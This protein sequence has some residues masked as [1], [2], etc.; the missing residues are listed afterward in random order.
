MLELFLPSR[1]IAVTNG[2]LGLGKWQGEKQQILPPSVQWSQAE[3]G[4]V[5]A[6][7]IISN[8]RRKEDQEIQQLI[9]CHLIS[10]SFQITKFKKTK[11]EEEIRVQPF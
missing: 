4:A 5:T 7:F 2:L 11:Q 9:F 10:F 3:L 8:K 1:L 6:A